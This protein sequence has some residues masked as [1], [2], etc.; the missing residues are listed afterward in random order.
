MLHR[1]QSEKVPLWALTIGSLD[2]YVIFYYIGKFPVEPKWG[3][4][5]V[6]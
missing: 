1:G 3:P 2:R 6:G 4:S 5:P